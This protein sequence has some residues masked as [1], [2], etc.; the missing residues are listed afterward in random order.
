MF[1]LCINSG[2]NNLISIK[3]RIDELLHLNLW[4]NGNGT[5]V[6]SYFLQILESLI[7]LNIF[8]EIHDFD[9]T[10][11]TTSEIFLYLLDNKDLGDAVM[12][13]M[14][15]FSFFQK[16]YNCII[17][18]HFKLLS[19]IKKSKFYCKRK[20]SCKD[21]VVIGNSFIWNI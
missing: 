2:F 9:K 3:Q 18:K 16:L 13:E 1:L 5:R 8:F 4:N 15:A 10:T 7:Y 6:C 19:L 11:V 21:M 14:L 12:K 17:W 20:P